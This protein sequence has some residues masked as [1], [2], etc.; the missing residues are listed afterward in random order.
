MENFFDL[1]IEA[2]T[3]SS[4]SSSNKKLPLPSPVNM[5]AL[6][7][8]MSYSISDDEKYVTFVFDVKGVEMKKII[9][10][11]TLKENAT[12]ED[13]TKFIA[14]RDRLIQDLQNLAKYLGSEY[15]PSPV[16]SFKQLID[17]LF[18]NAK[19]GFSDVR[20][21]IVYKDKVVKVPFDKAQGKSEEELKSKYT[22]YTIISKNSLYWFKYFDSK[23]EFKIDE[24][25]EFIDYEVIVEEPVFPSTEE[26]LP[27][28]NTTTEE[29][30]L[31]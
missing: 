24:T 29:E 31:F 20:L 18:S 11:P 15:L 27:F 22:P 3:T 13:K 10:A 7:T 2:P 5:G 16:K 6:G 14:Q 28:G 23:A 9:Y 17:L 21:K 4:L 1:N 30:D 8:C 12:E 25:R 19:L 26:D